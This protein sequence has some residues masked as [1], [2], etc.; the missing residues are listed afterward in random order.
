MENSRSGGNV[1]RR[2]LWDRQGTLVDDWYVLRGCGQ[3]C[4]RLAR[5]GTCYADVFVDRCG[6]SR[7]IGKCVLL[8]VVNKLA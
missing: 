7:V 3:T 6:T 5:V 8:S 1:S 4:V 2:S